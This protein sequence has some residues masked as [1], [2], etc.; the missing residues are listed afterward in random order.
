MT[1]RERVLAAVEHRQPDRTPI[2]LGAMR[3]TG[4]MALAYARLREH[5]GMAEGE[6]F[7][8]DVVQGL[9][10][11]EDAILDR[12]G[13]DV[14]DLGRAFLTEP[15][16]RSPFALTDGTPATVPAWFT[17]ESDGHGGYVVRDDAGRQIG[18]MPSSQPYITQT[19]HPLGDGITEA[20]LS[21]LPDHMGRVTW[22]GL[23]TAPWHLPSSPRDLE[24]IGERA[25][26]FRAS[27]DRAIMVACGCNLLEWG[28]FL[29][30]FGLFLEDLAADPRG[31]HRLLDRLMEI[32]VETLERVMPVLGPHVD[33]IQMGDDLGTQA[34]PQISPSMYRTFFKTRH[35]AIYRRAKELSGAKI[36]LHSCGG[37]A[38]LLPDL[39]EAG[40]EIINPVQ[41]SAAGMDPGTLK[42]EF[43]A[44]LCFWGGG[45]DTQ[46][47]LR[48][49]TP[50]EV[51]AQVRERRRILGEGGGFVFCQIHN[52]LPGV[53]PANVVAMLDA[54][55]EP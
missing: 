13:I 17:P 23:A 2:D 42:R 38:P 54:A 4:M 55:R 29:R 32:H 37:I 11:P 50:D 41:T 51:R 8:Y 6:V 16:E 15:H 35:Q 39:I 20:A 1:S 12:F 40:V 26:A 30:G 49:G 5:L 22:G 33:I 27:T 48:I 36:F 31:A 28:Q 18:T 25:E 19:Y 44:D 47:L 9:A 34:G 53:P 7:V 45:V 24:R 21:D 3:S 52:V 14:V 43:G 46:S 10:Q